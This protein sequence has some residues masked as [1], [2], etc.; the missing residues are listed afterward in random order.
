MAYLGKALNSI[1]TANIAV[2]TMTGDGSTDTMSIS[3]GS[4]LTDSVNNVSVFI[5]GVFQRPGTDYTLSGSTITFTTAPSDGYSVVAVSKGDSW[6]DVVADATVYGASIADNSLTDAKII[7][8]DASKLTGAMPAIDG[9]AVTNLP[10]THTVS[11]NDP[12]IDTNPSEGVG[13]LWINSTSG[14]VFCCTD[15]TADANVWFNVGGGSGDVEPFHG[16]GSNYGYVAGGYADVFSDVIDRFSFVSATDAT[17]VGNLFSGRGNQSGTSSST[18]GYAGGGDP[19]IGHD[20]TIQKWTFSAT[21]NATDVG[22]MQ[23]SA[24]SRAGFMSTTH[25]YAAGGSPTT[26]SVDKYAYASDGNSVDLC[27]LHN[28]PIFLPAGATSHTAGY[29]AGGRGGS[30]FTNF[31]HIEK[32]TFAADSSSAD[33]ADLANTC[34]GHSGHNSDTH[35]YVAGGY[36][37]NQI[38]KFTFA[39]ATNATD[40][41]DI[42]FGTA[43]HMSGNS[44]TTHG[45]ITTPEYINQAPG[46]AAQLESIEK[47]SFAS[48][49]DS[50]DSNQNLTLGRRHAGANQ[51]QY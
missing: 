41:S 6:K 45:Y 4:K 22:D 51:S 20:N 31:N 49:T 27:N 39:S 5:S 1:S 10:A 50:V 36:S 12:A 38:Q 3:L 18:H 44:S 8:L 7:G 16:W 33:H 19:N 32:I 26:D 37:N 17:D 42:R 23:T 24:A 21:A 15:A 47:F 13:A 46:N 40:V 25:G 29:T 28:G 30:P 11:A 9:S 48:G 43:G 35:G 2:D 34:K 14:E